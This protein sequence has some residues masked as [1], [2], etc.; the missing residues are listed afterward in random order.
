MRY[1]RLFTFLGVFALLGMFTS[2][3]VR[4]Q[5]ATEGSGLITPESWNLLG[6][7]TQPFGAAPPQAE[8]QRN[9]VP[10]PEGQ[11]PRSMFD[12]PLVGDEWE[13]DFAASPANGYGG[14]GIT[15]VPT[16]FTYDS[17]EEAFELAPGAIPRNGGGVD[18]Q[19]LFVW[20]QDN[21]NAA[22]PDAPGIPN[23]NVTIIGKTYVNN[24]TGGLLPI[25]ICASSDDS[26]VVYVNNSIAVS[27]SGGRGWGDGVGCQ[28][29]GAACLNP[30][31]NSITVVCSEGGGGWGFRVRLQNPDGSAI[32]SG[33]ADVEFLGPEGEGQLN[34]TVTR[35]VTPRDFDRP[36][37]PGELVEVILTG[38]GES[39]DDA[40]PVTLVETLTAGDNAEIHVEGGIATDIFGTP[41][42]SFELANGALGVWA[43]TRVVGSDAGGNS[44]TVEEAGDGQYTNTSSTGSDIWTNGDSFQYD[45]V[46]ASGDFDFS[47]R[48]DD[49]LND[50]EGRS[51]WGKFGPMARKT[52]HSD[53]RFTMAQSTIHTNPENAGEND[54]D[55]QAGRTQ[56]RVANGGMYED[57]LG[58]PND[59]E[60]LGHPTYTRIRRVGTIFQA[61]WSNDPAVETDPTNEALWTAFGREDDWGADAD[62]PVYVGFANSDHGDG[63]ANNQ[64]IT[65][66]ILN[67][68]YTP[69][70]ELFDPPPPPPL[71]GKEIVIE[72]TRGEL[73]AGLSYEVT[74][75]IPGSINHSGEIVGECGGVGGPGS[76]SYA[77]QSGEVG[78]FENALDVGGPA[79]QGSTTFNPEDNSYTIVGQGADIW[80]GGDQMQFAYKQWTGDFVATV[81]VRERSPN[82]TGRWGKHGIMARQ[83]LAFDSRYSMAMTPSAN[84]TGNPAEQDFSAHQLRSGHL[85]GGGTSNDQLRPPA[86]FDP[87]PQFD[88]TRAKPKWQRLIRKGQ[89]FT[90]FFADDREGAPGPWIPAGG[91]THGEMPDTVLLGIAQTSHGAESI[92][93]VY[94]NWSVE[95]PAELPPAEN[96]NAVALDNASFDFEAA[97]AEFVVNSNAPDSF[98]PQIVDGRLRMLEDGINSLGTSA[99]LPAPTLGDGTSLGDAGFIA[100]FD[101]YFTGLDGEGNPIPLPGSKADGVTFAIVESG[102][103]QATGLVGGPGGAMGFAGGTMNA[104]YADNGAQ[105]LAVELDTWGSGLGG[106]DAIVG[107]TN[108]NPGRW[109][110]GVDASANVIS[111]QNHGHFTGNGGVDS[112]PA[113]WDPATMGAHVEVQYLPIG[114]GM[115]NMKV[116]TSGNDGVFPR[117]LMLDTCVPAVTGDLLFGFTGGSG[118]ANMRFEVDNLEI[119][120][121][122]LE[123]PDSLSVDGP[124]VQEPG[125]TFDLTAS[126]AGADGVVNYQWIV[127]SGPGSIDGANN[128]EVVSIT[129]AEAGTS[130]VRVFAD[131]ELCGNREVVNYTIEWAC[132]AEGDTTVD[133]FEYSGPADDEPGD[134]TFTAT[135]SDAS[136]DAISYS[137]SVVDSDSGTEVDSAGPQADGVAT[138]NLLAGNYDV[139]VTADDSDVCDDP[140]GTSTL[141]LTVTSPGGIQLPG[142]TNQDGSKDISDEIVLLGHLFLGDPSTLPCGGGNVLDA[143]NIALLDHNGD[144]AIDISDVISGLGFLFL[145]QA[146]HAGGTAC[147]PIP[148][149]PD[150]NPCNDIQ[151]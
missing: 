59:R 115:A 103:Q 113:A 143:G 146:P 133:S 29:T 35:S 4:A 45:Y 58:T 9:W 108:N 109:H 2:E 87:D 19:Q 123:S 149:C 66:T 89:H 79:I 75:N 94:D 3:S 92:T 105:S 136:G 151:L 5:G 52:L 27:H 130:L 7:L 85:T 118:G 148:D 134:F 124:T 40:D 26:I 119:S 127:L 37:G 112:V 74:Y 22:I 110:F 10:A 141:S 31:V 65:Y 95:R 145:G 88:G 25:Q 13:I 18:A 135:A 86:V 11:D 42:E 72:T 97:P 139:T 16:W 107:G 50:A 100:R 140:A 81:R 106:G 71:I 147:I 114:D 137:F 121:F 68:D 56:H 48:Y 69:A 80:N 125:S 46:R 17:L 53:S 60:D 24:T 61:F 43:D 6:P 128:E 102:L 90:V 104:L 132:P 34:Y 67:L 21:V 144:N 91:F 1:S 64:A 55:R 20:L 12:D 47:I 99:W 126:Y 111:I 138:F 8:Q 15:T 32:L 129:S 93:N 36:A 28:N 39:G 63:G 84:T 38:N 122:C 44:G 116:W 30:G 83:S 150:V 73:N 142:D 70:A 77:V 78:A 23:D 14:G 101:A 131:D 33:G 117:T 62:S 51:R 98:V 96:F 57:A 82:P 76:T 41:D 54:G 49:R 120:S